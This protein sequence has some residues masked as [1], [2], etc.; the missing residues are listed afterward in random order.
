M[1]TTHEAEEN[2]S[3]QLQNS[4]SQIEEQL[5]DLQEDT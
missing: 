4:N 5:M 1:Q 2:T 3:L